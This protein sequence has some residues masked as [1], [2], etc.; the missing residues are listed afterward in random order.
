VPGLAD[1]PFSRLLEEVAAPT[2]A[3]GGGS[4]SALAAA[5]AAALVEM[6]ARLA[7]RRE[8][9]AGGAAR[10]PARVPERA[11]ALRARALE[12]AERELGSYAQVLEARRLPPEDPAREDRLRAALV[13]AS[14]A[15]IE[16]AEAA[17]EISE[18][19]AAVAAGSTPSVR[20]DALAGGLL[21]AAAADAAASLVE[22]NLADAP[23]APELG[24]ARA[25]RE[26]ARSA[27]ASLG[28]R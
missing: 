26:R 16:I 2:P 8:A 14:G 12:L 5:L 24:R 13:E 22:I 4:S 15:P 20:G 27:A 11:G 7:L 6:A 25:A 1:Q 18:L 3:P 23:D 10:V 21:A 28:A 19:A 9:A 17:A